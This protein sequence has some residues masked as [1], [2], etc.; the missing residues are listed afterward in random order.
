MGRDHGDQP[1]AGVPPVARRVL[2]G[3]MKARHGRIINIAS[4]VGASGNAGQANYAAAK[5]GVVG[6]TKSL[7]QEIGSRN[8]TVNCVAPGFIDTD[9]TRALTDAQR[10][11]LLGQIPL[12]RLGAPEDIARAVV[13][14]A[15]PQAALHHGRD[16][17]R[18]RRHVHGLTIGPALPAP[19]RK[20][21]RSGKIPRFSQY[22]LPL[23][24]SCMENIE[25]RVKKIVAEQLGVNEGE[26]KNESSF[27]D[28]LGA[29][30]LDTVELV[31]ALEEEFETEIPDEEA[32]KITT[33]QQAV[34]YIKAHQKS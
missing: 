24:R 14:L 6:F 17:A 9:M 7:A 4:V 5:A 10:Q 2:R 1:Q 34:D 19:G 12:G 20:P 32:E 28:D 22:R 3:M 11:A 31:M 18:Q 21:R 29:D 16:A 8:I 25:Q 30:S 26:I 15:S 33:V 13:F 23:G 27:V